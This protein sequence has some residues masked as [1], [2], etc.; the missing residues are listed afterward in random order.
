MIS[1]LVSNTETAVQAFLT[2][3]SPISYAFDLDKNTNFKGNKRFAVLTGKATEV[4]S[5]TGYITVIQ[6]LKILIASSFSEPV[7]D[8]AARDAS[9][10]IADSLISLAK[11]LAVN[12]CNTAGVLLVALSDITDTEYRD[13]INMVSRVATINVT[14]RV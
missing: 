12:K 6:E 2:D 11:H 5:V 9:N 10:T 1:T 4:D 14:Y 7:N 8:T 3:H 13:T